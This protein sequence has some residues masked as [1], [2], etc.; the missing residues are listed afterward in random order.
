MASLPDD[1]WLHDETTQTLSGRRSRRV[2]SLAQELTVRLKEARPVTGGLVF[3]L[4]EAGPAPASTRR[5]K[6]K[7]QTRSESKRPGKTPKSK[8]KPNR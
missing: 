8:A 4:E 2:F 3:A 6:A 1:Y 5:R 7:P